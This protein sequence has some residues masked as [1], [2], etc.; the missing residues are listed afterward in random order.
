MDRTSEEFAEVQRVHDVLSKAM[1]REIWQIA[2]LMVSKRD[3]QL[4][5]QTEFALRTRY[6]GWGRGS[7]ATID[8][9]KRVPRQRCLPRLRQARFV[10]WRTRKIVS[11]GAM[12]VDAAYHC[13]HCRCKTLGVPCN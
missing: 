8:D 13:R 1:D 5:G 10:G 11:D 2:E 6:Y 3:D 7:E 12:D 4:L 9:R